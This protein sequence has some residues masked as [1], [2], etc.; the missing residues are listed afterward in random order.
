MANR[1]MRVAMEIG[2][3][4]D[5]SPAFTG[6]YGTPITRFGT[7]CM[8]RGTGG[9]ISPLH[10]SERVPGAL[11]DFVCEFGF[12]RRRPRDSGATNLLSGSLMKAR[13]RLVSWE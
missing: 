1:G 11:D 8:N 7:E 4:C 2:V 3:S 12:G 6:I 13:C 10:G 5:P 9:T